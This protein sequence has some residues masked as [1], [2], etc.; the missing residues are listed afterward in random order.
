[1]YLKLNKIVQLFPKRVKKIILKEERVIK[2][3]LDI[4]LLGK[5]RG[6]LSWKLIFRIAI[7]NIMISKSRSFITIGAI[8]IGVGAVIFLVAFSYGLQQ[9]VTSRLVRPN[10]FRL[11]EVQSDSTALKLNNNILDDIKSLA[12]VE[13]V[14]P[15]IILAGMS[16]FSGSK[17]DAVVIALKNSNIDYSYLEIVAGK[18]FSK[19]ADADYTGGKHEVSDLQRLV[20][21]KMDKK[22]EVAGASTADM[23]NITVGQEISSK[24]IHFRARDYVYLPV[25]KGPTISGY[26]EGFIRGS[27]LEI[28]DGKEVWGGEYQTT[29]TEGKAILGSDGQWYGRWIKA[30]LPI[31]KEEAPTVYIE[32]K[33]SEGKQVYIEGYV[34]YRDVHVL[35]S[36][37][38]SIEKDL[39]KTSNQSTGEVLGENTEESASSSSSLVTINAGTTIA[40]EAAALQ[41]LVSARN[42]TTKKK[43]GT[44]SSLIELKRKTG[45]EAIVSTGFLRAMKKD[46]KKVVDQT[47]DMQFIVSGGLI[48]GVDGRVISK[49]V[50]YKI[51]GV[52]K[53]ETKPV[54]YIPIADAQSMGIN[55]FSSMTVLA[56]SPSMLKGVRN[57]IESLGLVTRSIVDTLE[58]VNKL[59]AVM[60]YLLASF[61]F[62]AFV[63]AII[64]MFNTLTVTLL[65]RTREVAVMKTI[66]TT[67]HDVSRLFFVESLVIGLIGGLSGIV[68]GLIVGNLF[69]LLMLLLRDDK[70]IRLFV[71][72]PAFLLVML[73][74]S[75]LVGALTGIYPASRARNINPLDALRYE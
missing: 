24:V 60:R 53:D 72:P 32:L 25:R 73:F 57:Q 19:E 71:F 61:G 64:G 9:L 44:A 46:P 75:L 70:S 39:E 43:S 63:V 50:T 3:E 69:D 54:I 40:T 30:K 37:E 42:T 6:Y 55:S 22:G 28:Y 23:P 5:K 14:S 66:G 62:I 52:I 13:D 33:N 45:H 4:D 68:F 20:E 58:Q 48:S 18:S 15:A 10:S 51:V 17:M 36:D 34:P 2:E 41:K 56:K 49:S 27:V 12:G 16:T 29:G 21:E 8:A 11:V 38:Y 47:I 1:M 35:S 74:V 26:V 67:N 65:E 31:Y 59:F 7:K